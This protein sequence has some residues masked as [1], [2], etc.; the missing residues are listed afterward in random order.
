MIERDGQRVVV[1]M[2]YHCRPEGCPVSF[3]AKFPGCYNARRDNLEKFWRNQFGFSHGLLAMNAFYENVKKHDR[4]HRPLAP[5]E[6]PENLILKF[7]PQ[8]RQDMLVA[9]IWSKWTGA[10]GE[11]LLSFAVITDDPPPEVA[12]EGHDR[13]PVPIKAENVDAW[14]N[15]NRNNLQALQDILEDRERPFYDHRVLDLM[16]A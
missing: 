8:P 15:P 3:D 14:L 13:C 16:A 2:R 9:C 4:E 10:D 11:E 7:E 5:G 6:E 12:A 1:P